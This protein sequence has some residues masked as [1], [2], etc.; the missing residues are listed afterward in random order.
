MTEEEQLNKLTTVDRS[1]ADY[2]VLSGGMGA[3][4]VPQAASTETDEDIKNKKIAAMSQQEKRV[5]INSY[6]MDLLGKSR[7]AIIETGEKVLSPQARKLADSMSL[8]KEPTLSQY[9]VLS[10]TDKQYL[11]QYTRAINPA[12]DEAI[13]TQFA[14]RGGQMLEDVASSNVATINRMTSGPRSPK[15]LYEK[16]MTSVDTAEL[17]KFIDTGKWSSPESEQQ[18]RSAARDIVRKLP[19]YRQMQ[20]ITRSMAATG[21]DQF[22]SYGKNNVEE[23]LVDNLLKDAKVKLYEGRELANQHR[24]DK[25]VKGATRKMFQS[26]TLTDIMVEGPVVMAD[27]A[28][29][30][31]LGIPTAGAGTV[32]YSA[33]RV[34]GDF[35]NDL[36]YEH[37][38][39]PDDA[40]AIG[41]VGTMV[42]TGIELA[43]LKTLTATLNK[44]QS[45]FMTSFTEGLPAFS[46]KI[47]QNQGKVMA[48]IKETAAV[49]A[50]ETSEESAQAMTEQFMKAYAKEYADAE[51]VEYSELVSNWWDQTL[52]SMSAMAF[53]AGSRGV[54][55]FAAAPGKGSYDNLTMKESINANPAGLDLNLVASDFSDMSPAL[56]EELAEAET[57]EDVDAIL[58]ENNISMTAQDFERFQNVGTEVEL[59]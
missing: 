46:K 34:Y 51:K 33:S 13:F 26:D 41:T 22:N 20:K 53:I 59:D 54:G 38:V 52:D 27:M 19:E 15:R 3:V 5:A 49:F 9:S 56:Q 18:A 32:A 23:Q 11:F 17:D 42:Y 28:V 57:Q 35:V 29:A 7:R 16:F 50:I 4:Y 6:R 40:I 37:N 1:S 44:V 12:V 31:A 8:G 36:I 10:T 30:I 39:D 21:G 48:G 55:A 25:A 45:K 58:A 47:A 43:Q 14:Q 24:L 2:G